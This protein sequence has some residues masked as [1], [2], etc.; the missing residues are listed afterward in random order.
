MSYTEEGFLRGRRGFLASSALLGLTG[1]LAVSTRA[2]TVPRVALVVG[3]SRYPG[4]PLA[5]A[6]NDAELVASTARNLGFKVSLLLNASS[7]SLLEAVKLW[8][9]GTVQAEARM[10]YFAG[11]GAQYRG[12][13]F[14]IPVDARLHSEDDLP[15]VA[16]SV[17][18]LAD[19]LSRFGSGVSVVV[20]D[21]CRSIPS[22]TAPPGVRM[23][24]APETP[25]TPGLLAASA[26]KGALIAYS[27][28][29]GAVAADS[30]QQKN[31]LYTRH[32]AKNMGAPG[33]PIED[34][35]KLTR[36]AVLQESAGTQMPWETSSLVGS[37]CFSLSSTGRCGTDSASSR[38][39]R[40]SVDPPSFIGQ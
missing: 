40:H 24:G 39:Q 15:A 2:E 22:L 7:A 8:L 37:F 26:P 25:W 34:V 11:H 4:A 5:N 23:R 38:S 14:L 30:P 19:R 31:G 18:D 36:A 29:P 1:G 6:V 10:L 27:T 17:N 9:D 28:S 32:L 16:F 21:A 35:F 12:R 33:L 20:L 3:N 13:N